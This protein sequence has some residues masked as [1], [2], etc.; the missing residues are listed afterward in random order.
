MV[1]AGV[2]G[3]LTGRGADILIIDDPVKNSE[4]ANS[5]TYRERAWDWFRSVAMTRLEPNASV[6][7]VATRWHEDDLIGRVTR[8]DPDG[9]RVV[10]LPAIAEEVDELGRQPGDALWSDRFPLQALGGDQGEHWFRC[11][12]QAMYQ[13]H[14]TPLSGDVFPARVVSYVRPVRDGVPR[15]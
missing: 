8:V 7:I 3:P 15:R 4:E 12:W 9:W 5:D 1:T 14:P 11:W 6:I 10:N 13:C 2:G